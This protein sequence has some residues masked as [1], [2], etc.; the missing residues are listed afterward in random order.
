MRLCH[1]K[2]KHLQVA[3][4][5]LKAAPSSDCEQ[6]RPRYQ[7]SAAPQAQLIILIR[8]TGICNYCPVAG[9]GSSLDETM[10]WLCEASETRYNGGKRSL[11]SSSSGL[12]Q[13]F[14]TEEKILQGL[15]FAI[16]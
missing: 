16:L 10:N 8:I 1:V 5:K 2:P 9:E 11:I 3:F 13:I 6:S 15:L 4:S 14:Y 7:R 12:S